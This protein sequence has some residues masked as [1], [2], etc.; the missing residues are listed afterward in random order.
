MTAS[1]CWV[2]A[3]TCRF[4]SA[5]VI[6]FVFQALRDEGFGIALAEAMAA[7]LP[8]VATNVGACREVLE[9]GRCGCCLSLSRIRRPWRTEFC[10]LCGKVK[11]GFPHKGGLSACHCRV[12]CA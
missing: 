10:R 9:A 2:H 11:R 12:F 1:N 3:E 7:R 5:S 4:F 8:I 6:F